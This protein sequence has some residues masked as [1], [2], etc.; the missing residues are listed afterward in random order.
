MTVRTSRRMI[1]PLSSCTRTPAIAPL[2]SCTKTPAIALRP[3]W[4]AAAAAG[5]EATYAT[6]RQRR[7]K[8]R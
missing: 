1:A 4:V 3:N 7:E 2:S 6:G 8:L 5:A